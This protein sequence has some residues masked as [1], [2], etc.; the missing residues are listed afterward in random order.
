ML[1][2][3]G[4]QGSYRIDAPNERPCA[5]LLEYVKPFC[6]LE[7]GVIENLLDMSEVHAARVVL[8]L[9]AQIEEMSLPAALAKHFIYAM[10]IQLSSLSGCPLAEALRH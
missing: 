10:M 7:R 6:A 1:T 5:G 4:G 2:T 8:K 3:T 9:L